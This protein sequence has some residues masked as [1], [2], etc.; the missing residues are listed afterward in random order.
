MSRSRASAPGPPLFSL[1]SS[2]AGGRT[3]S[4]IAKFPCRSCR[5]VRFVCSMGWLGPARCAGL[6]RSD[7]LGWTYHP[8][9]DGTRSS[10]CALGV[11]V[12]S[13]RV[14][15]GGDNFGQR[16]RR[17]SSDAIAG[18]VL[19]RARPRAFKTDKAVFD[20]RVQRAKAVERFSSRARGRVAAC[21]PRAKLGVS[22]T[23]PKALPRTVPKGRRSGHPR[24]LAARLDPVGLRA[25]GRAS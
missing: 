9:A 10:V 12:R 16:T 4:F 13:R 25:H 15:I 18:S 11:F 8:T 6:V 1:F 17:I 23:V 19:F 22:R 21:G 24:T 14:S 7:G 5:R 20:A 2:R 3:C